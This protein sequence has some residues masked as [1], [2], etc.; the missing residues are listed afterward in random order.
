MQ[1]NDVLILVWVISV[2][3][4][5][6]LQGHGALMRINLVILLLHFLCNLST[7]RDFIFQRWSFVVHCL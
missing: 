4:F 5:N 7:V 1:D 6:V 2:L 3:F